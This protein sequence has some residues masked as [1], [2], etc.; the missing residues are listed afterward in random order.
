[1]ETSTK[2]ITLHIIHPMYLRE[3]IERKLIKRFGKLYI[4]MYRTNLSM[5]AI[6]NS[7]MNQ[8]FTIPSLFFIGYDRKIHAP[9]HHRSEDVGLRKGLSILLSNP[10]FR[11]VGRDEDDR[12]LLVVCLCHGRVEV[13]QCRT[14]CD[15][16]GDWFGA[17]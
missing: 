4:N 6:D 1:M 14:R 10:C 12:Q 7:L 11:A 3:S 15:A 5:H 13:E 2:E 17:L 9:V 16:D 8:P